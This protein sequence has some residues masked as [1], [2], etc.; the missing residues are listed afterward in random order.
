MKNVKKRKLM[1]SLLNMLE[2]A[3]MCLNKQDS[4]YILS[5][6][7]AKILNMGKFWIW[8]GF[9]FWVLNSL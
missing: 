9:K 5:L 6:K 2:F 7:F 4:E 8:K 3:L 1:L